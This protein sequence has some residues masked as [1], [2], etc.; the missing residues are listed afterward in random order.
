MRSAV[1]DAQWRMVTNSLVTCLFA[2]AIYDEKIVLEGLGALG[3][4]WDAEKLGRLGEEALGRKYAYKIACGADPRR[5]AI[6][7]KLFTV[8]TA[9]GPVDRERMAKRMVLYAQLVG[10]PEEA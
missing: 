1:R 6:P 4:A 10:L 2:R 3:L 8:A 7:E 9:T 5:G